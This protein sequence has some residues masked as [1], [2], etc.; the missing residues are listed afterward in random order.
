MDACLRAAGVRTVADLSG[1]A[2]A[3]A[4]RAGVDVLKMSHEELI[5][6]GMAER[7]FEVPAPA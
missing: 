3:E 5:E 4:A 7:G 2:A 6:A 1:K